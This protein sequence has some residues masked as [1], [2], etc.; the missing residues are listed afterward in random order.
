MT[1]AR[2]ILFS[3]IIVALALLASAWLWTTDRVKADRFELANTGAGSTV[4]L[5][6]QAG[7]LLRCQGADCAAIA[8]NGKTVLSK[9]NPSKARSAPQ[10]FDGASPDFS[11]P[12]PGFVLDEQD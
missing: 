5:D 2:A 9:D 4:R 6:K 1:T 12:P 10:N 11:P 8:K 7:D 3:S